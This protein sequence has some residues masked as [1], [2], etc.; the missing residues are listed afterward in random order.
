MNSKT[1]ASHY[2]AVETKVRAVGIEHMLHRMYA[3]DFNNHGPS[4]KGEGTT[5]MLVENRSFVI[6]MEKPK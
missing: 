5:E 3:A 6:L 2:F 1:V 4:K